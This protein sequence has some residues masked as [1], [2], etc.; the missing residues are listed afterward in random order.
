MKWQMAENSIFAMLLRAPWWASL[1]IAVIVTGLSFA[2]L[3][4]G[5]VVFG[6]AAA[7]PFIVIAVMVLWRLSKKPRTAVVE[8]TA[9]RARS[10][11]AKT[12]GAELAQGFA[13]TGHSVV[14]V[15]SDAL[16]FVVTKGWRV[17]VVSYRKWK[18]AHLGVEPLRAL[19]NARDDHEANGA[20]IVV[21]GDLSGPA[22][23]FVLQNNIEIIGPEALAGLIPK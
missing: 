3:P 9:E 12:F 19:F 17:N 2:V 4:I 22:T 18:A 14:H 8:A 15:K 16:D 23:K 10:L 1:G 21:L 6:L 13:R 20:M 11:N 7:V 5:Y